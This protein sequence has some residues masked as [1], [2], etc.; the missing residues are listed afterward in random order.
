MNSALFLK[1]E[2]QKKTIESIKPIVPGKLYSMEYTADYKLDEF[3]NSGAVLLDDFTR[4]AA[5]SLLD[6]Q[7]IAAAQQA[8]KM[9]GFGGGCSAFT[10]WNAAG[11][12]LFC[13]GYD[14]PHE[15][16]VLLVHTHP[17]NG[18]RSLGTADLSF[19]NINEGMF[20]D[21]KTDLSG[22]M[23]APYVVEDGVNE[24]GV[25]IAA[26]A[27]SH[28]GVNQNTGKTR[29]PTTVII[30]TVLDRAATTDEAI[31]LFKSYDICTN[32]PDSDFHFIIYDANGISKVVE[33]VNQHINVIDARYINNQYMTPYMSELVG[34]PR[35]RMLEC[36]SVHRK[37]QFEVGDALAMLRCVRL[38]EYMYG[39]NYNP[40]NHTLWSYVAN[41]REKKLHFAFE[42]D[43]DHIMEFEV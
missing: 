5:V 1:T 31:D 38:D 28:R 2:E 6:G 19:M 18:Y 22:L 36:F 27:L 35:F 4:F 32:L 8:A 3:I 42:R 13:R 17:E 30:R 9:N 37:D 40:K 11:E 26:L 15:P 24:K 21:G 39:K 23:L 25:C 16:T 7:K 34:E 14:F 10:G 20:E 43:F 29:I 33:Y 12:P 41:A